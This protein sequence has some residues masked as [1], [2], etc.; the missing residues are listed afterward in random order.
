M[1]SILDDSRI[2]A[3]HSK[4]K[5]VDLEDVRLAIKLQL[6]QTFTNPPPRDVLID[7]AKT[8]N[9]VALPFVKHS[10]GL[11]LPPDRYCLNG[12]NYKI[13]PA[14]KS[15]KMGF[16]ANSSFGQSRIGSHKTLSIVKRPGALSTM[17]RPQTVSTNKPVFKINTGNF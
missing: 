15:G 10:N 8:K 1:T 9:S 16:N 2:Y 4:K 12:A 5:V 17:A 13:K 14:K 11:R 3:N 7:I 6:E